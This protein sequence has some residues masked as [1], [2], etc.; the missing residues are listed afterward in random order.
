MIG[1]RMKITDSAS[2]YDALVNGFDKLNDEGREAEA[3]KKGIWRGGTSGCITAKGQVLG[4]DPR[5]AVL[6]Y[7]G[8]QMP[9]D[10]D[11]Q[12]MFDAGL[13]NEDSFVNLLSKSGVPFKTEEDIPMV[14][15][16]SNGDKVTGRPDVVI[17]SPDGEPTLGI[18][19]KLICSENSAMTK[20]LF[21]RETVDTKH[22]IQACN[23]A[24]Y[25]GIPWS[26]VYTSRMLYSVP[27]YAKK[28][29][30]AVEK[31]FTHAEHRAVRNDPKTGLPYM[32]RPFQSLYDITLGPD[33]DTFYLNG[34]PTIITK[35]GID[36]YY[37]YCAECIAKKEVPRKRSGSVDHFG[38]AIP[39][40]KNK[41]IKYDDFKAARTG[42]GFD[43]WVEDCRKIAE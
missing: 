23:Y 35:S 14:R 12:L 16:L 7:L 40:A 26:L 24:G 13:T 18:E 37:E 15:E 27:Y 33:G 17:L 4:A 34:E 21:G 42:K 25:F 39:K 19:L 28:D 43:I 36:R 2:L 11:T 3:K 8:I 20:A 32:I 29:A 22:L 30:R 1:I 41:T 5:Q 38:K 31:F 9:T 6:R 10:Y